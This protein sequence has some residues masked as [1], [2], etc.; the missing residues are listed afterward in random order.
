[1]DASY[2]LAYMNDIQSPERDPLIQT[3]VPPKAYKAFQR[4]A[5]NRGESVAGLTRKLVLESVERPATRACT[6][7]R[8]GSPRFIDWEL[9]NPWC[10]LWEVRA[11]S[12]SER[13]FAL[14]DPNGRPISEEDFARSPTLS[15]PTERFYRLRGSVAPWELIASLY[16]ERRW[17]ELTL[18]MLDPDEVWPNG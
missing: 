2:I 16:I 4:L 15:R 6:Q 7:P 1:M 17:M 12:A 14:L 5:E 9:V 11:F 18:R 8:K 10:L 3:R 13:V